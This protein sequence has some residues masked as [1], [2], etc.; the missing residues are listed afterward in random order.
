MFEK[1]KTHLREAGKGYFDHARFAG[2]MGW[3]MIVG[4]IS[5]L[6]HALI[7]GI[8]PGHAD[9][10]GRYIKKSVEDLDRFR[11]KQ[12]LPQR[13]MPEKYDLPHRHTSKDPTNK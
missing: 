12:G 3:I 2:K 9:G 8:L 1:S 6:L 10:I 5:S 13:T 4:G 7:P 11:E